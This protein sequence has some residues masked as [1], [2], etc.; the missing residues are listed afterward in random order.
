MIQLRLGTAQD[1]PFL[2][3]MLYEAVYWRNSGPRP[4]FSDGLSDPELIKILQGWGRS[5]DTALIASTTQG[6]D[7]G[8]AWYRFWT[9]SYHSYGYVNQD[10]PEIGIA[11]EKPYRGQGIGSQLLSQLLTLA[12]KNGIQQLSLSVEEDN[13]AYFL[14]KKHRFKKVKVVDNSLTMVVSL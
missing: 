8:A 12:A 3:K 13:P 9:D 7:A 14:Y 6:K 11:L 10:T 1:F 4:P 2:E 5:G